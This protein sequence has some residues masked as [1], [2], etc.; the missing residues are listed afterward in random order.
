MTVV[1]SLE[2]AN[3]K[4]ITHVG[5]SG[6]TVTGIRNGDDLD[7]LIEIGSD[8]P[9]DEAVGLIGTF[10]AFLEETFDEAFVAACMGHYAAET[11]KEFHEAGDHKIVMVRGGERGRKRGTKG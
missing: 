9:Q 4:T 6:F 8:I 10:L 1:T 2:N 11:G 3:G 5:T 7:V